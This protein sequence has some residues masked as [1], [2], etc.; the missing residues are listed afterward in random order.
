MVGLP[1][2]PGSDTLNKIQVHSCSS[3]LKPWLWDW[4]AAV[5]LARSIF[6]IAFVLVDL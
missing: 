5:E 6:L 3:S 1:C 2:P 4:E